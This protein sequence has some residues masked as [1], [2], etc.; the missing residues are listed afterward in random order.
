MWLV[1]E[2]NANATDRWG[3]NAAASTASR[4]VLLLLLLLV[5]IV[6]RWH[7]HWVLKLL[8]LLMV[9]VRKGCLCTPIHRVL[10]SWHTLRHAWQRDESPE[11]DQ[12]RGVAEGR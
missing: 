1:R 9:R 2:R 10:R 3:S 7:C 6:V 11:G 4:R 5:V 8:L 12:G